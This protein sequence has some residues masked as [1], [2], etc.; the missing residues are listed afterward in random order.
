MRKFKALPVPDY[1]KLRVDILPSDKPLTQPQRPLFYAD[2]L[3]KKEKSVV[4]SVHDNKE[5]SPAGFKF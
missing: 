1:E 4:E 2:M 3:P 5:E